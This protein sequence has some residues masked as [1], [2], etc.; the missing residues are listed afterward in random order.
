[1][2][3]LTGISAMVLMQHRLD[4]SLALCPLQR[5]INSLQSTVCTELED[6]LLQHIPPSQK[7]I[8]FPRF[9]ALVLHSVDHDYLAL[10]SP[11]LCVRGRYLL[12]TAYWYRVKSNLSQKCTCDALQCAVNTLMRWSH[13]SPEVVLLA[14]DAVQGMHPYTTASH[15]LN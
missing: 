11:P 2:D 3:G 8:N 12:S 6:S 1:M 13:Y 4:V 9:K 5:K 15:P 14:P 7:Q 10:V